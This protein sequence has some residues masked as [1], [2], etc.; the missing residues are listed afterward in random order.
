MMDVS[1][2]V[3]VAFTIGSGLVGAGAAWGVMKATL[4]SVAKEATN[5]TEA[6]KQIADFKLTAAKDYVSTAA[7][8]RLEGRLD[9]GF[10]AIRDE[11]RDQNALIINALSAR[12]ARARARDEV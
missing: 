8:L 11:M 9:E 5:G 12:S 4:A 2:P 6:L 7:L 3:A 1:L 10:K